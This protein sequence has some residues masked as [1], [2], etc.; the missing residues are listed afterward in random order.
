MEVNEY[1]YQSVYREDDI[2]ITCILYT[3]ILCRCIVHDSIVVIVMCT[4]I[5]VLECEYLR[6]TR[7]IVCNS[8]FVIFKTMQHIHASTYTL[9]IQTNSIYASNYIYT[10]QYRLLFATTNLPRYA[11]ALT[12]PGIRNGINN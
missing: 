11:Q 10:H 9:H 1:M 4:K 7:Q 3:D 6:D 2:D 5:V 8:I 12:S